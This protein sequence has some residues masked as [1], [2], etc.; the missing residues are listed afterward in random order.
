MPIPQKNEKVRGKKAR[1]LASCHFLRTNPFASARSRESSFTR[2]SPE[3]REK[4]EKKKTSR[5]PSLEQAW[6]VPSQICWFFSFT[7][8][9]CPWRPWI[10]PIG[11]TDSTG[12]EAWGA[13]GVR[14]HKG[15]ARGKAGSVLPFSTWGPA[16]TPEGGGE[17]RG[18][19][20]PEGLRRFKGAHSF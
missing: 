20:F 15:K 9:V 2:L 7:V 8:T 5:P 10:Q 3:T 19:I 11:A 1:E 16:K 12:D 4:K 17:V 18:P 6:K 13:S 14:S